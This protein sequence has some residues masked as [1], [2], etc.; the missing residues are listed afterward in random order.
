LRRR[1]RWRGG[2]HGRRANPDPVIAVV[3]IAQKLVDAKAVIDVPLA[4]A[5]VAFGVLIIVDPSPVPRLTPP[6]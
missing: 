5:V 1:T 3:V 2:R 4:L 6:L